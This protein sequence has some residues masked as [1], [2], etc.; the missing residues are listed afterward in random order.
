MKGLVVLKA[1]DLEGVA[2]GRGGKTSGS[3]NASNTM[4]LTFNGA[5]GNVVNVKGKTKDS[6]DIGFTLNNNIN[7]QEPV[8]S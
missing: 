7:S 8:V 3:Y 5:G 6:G 4:G 2:G 1:L